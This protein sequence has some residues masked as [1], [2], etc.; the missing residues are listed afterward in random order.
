MTFSRSENANTE[1]KASEIEMQEVSAA[2][3]A[4]SPQEEKQAVWRL[5]IVLIP[6]YV[7]FHA[8]FA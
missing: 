8:L 6:L 3:L 1:A 7:P 4:Y 2:D 5:D